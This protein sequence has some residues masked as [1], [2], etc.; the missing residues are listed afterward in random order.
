MPVLGGLNAAI[1]TFKRKSN[2]MFV[3]DFWH[4][5]ESHEDDL[6]C[7]LTWNS[8]TLDKG[9]LRRVEIM[10]YLSSHSNANFG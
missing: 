9:A 5:V 3:P 10:N 8:R 2:Y 7:N 1:S 6:N 4:G